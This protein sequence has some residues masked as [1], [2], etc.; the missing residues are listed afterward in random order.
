MSVTWAGQS[1]SVNLATTSTVGTGATGT[2]VGPAGGD[3]A[4]S[5]PNPTVDGLQG[6][7]V[8]ATAPT[9]GQVLVWNATQWE[10]GAAPPAPIEERPAPR[11]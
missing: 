2:P 9:N 8:A 11:D 7:A 6:R 4:G 1:T 5:Y 10:P 3:L